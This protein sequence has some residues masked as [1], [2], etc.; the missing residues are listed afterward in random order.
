METVK[1]LLVTLL[2]ATIM[3]GIIP[4]TT[5]AACSIPKAVKRLD[6]DE[7][8]AIVIKQTNGREGKMFLY[9]RNCKSGKW[10]LKKSFRCIV[11]KKMC[12]TKHYHL[13]RS[14]DTDYLSFGEDYK[15]W[16]YGIHVDCRE[17]PING[18]IC[19]YVEEYDGR[20]WTVKKSVKANDQ[21]ITVCESNAKYIW[22]YYTDGVPVILL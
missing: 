11:G 12:K 16:N 9:K 22:K 19:S 4:V 2:L 10:E 20:T 5:E 13:Q 3:V 15:R 14:K 6:E 1:R 18:M 7:D 8:R 17:K 21:W